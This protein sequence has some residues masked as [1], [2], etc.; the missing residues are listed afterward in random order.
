MQFVSVEQHSIGNIL[1]LWHKKLM[2][3][4]RPNARL[5]LHFC[6]MEIE[7]HFKCIGSIKHDQACY[8]RHHICVTRASW[9]KISW[10][11]RNH[12]SKS[13]QMTVISRARSNFLSSYWSA[14]WTETRRLIDQR[15]DLIYTFDTAGKHKLKPQ[16]VKHTSRPS[17]PQQCVDVSHSS[18]LVVTE[19]IVCRVSLWKSGRRVWLIAFK[20][21][22]FELGYLDKYTELGLDH[23]RGG[24]ISLRDGRDGH[25]ATAARIGPEESALPWRKML[26]RGDLS[27]PADKLIDK[28]PR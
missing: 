26:I 13:I 4:S 5:N 7:K 9:A 22:I 12:V 10:R 21:A 3:Y 24:T 18:T 16:R 6:Q 2:H 28:W 19:S 23:P 1:P 27:P 15:D 25:V 8:H 14:R 17:F 20:S 11:Q